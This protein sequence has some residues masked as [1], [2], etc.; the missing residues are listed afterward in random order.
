M[1][2]PLGVSVLEEAF[3]IGVD[4]PA[5]RSWDTLMGFMDR[6][7][8]ELGVDVVSIS[9]LALPDDRQEA[10]GRLLSRYGYTP[11]GR[12]ALKIV[13]NTHG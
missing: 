7:A 8:Q 4:A 2:E 1:H 12:T 10:Y 11:S 6:T 9:S 3:I 13:R 5:K